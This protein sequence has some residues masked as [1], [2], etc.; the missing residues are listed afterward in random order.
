METLRAILAALG[1]MSAPDGVTFQ[2]YADAEMV[3]VA[4]TVAGRLLSLAV[5]RGGRIDGGQPLFVLDAV[6]EQATRDEAAARLAQA[7][8]RLTDLE[9]GLRP[10][11]IEA[12]AAQKTEAEALLR[13]T[14]LRLER[15]RKLRDSA[16]FMPDRLDE[17]QATRD[18]AR[19][20]VAALAAQLAVARLGGREDALRAARN[21]IEADR[22]ALA[23]AEWTLAQKV[24]AAPAGGLVYDTLFRPGENVGVGQPVVS[25]LPPANRKV[26]FFVPEAQLALVAPGAVVAIACDG[27]GEPIPARVN[28]VSPQAEFTPPVLYN[29]DN[30]VRLVFMVEARPTARPEALH[31]GQPVDVR[32]SPP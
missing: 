13:L 5:Q 28:W 11:E 27:C 19:A 32:M 23:R 10:E 4:P 22:A 20:R 14:D 26:R 9:K 7:E 18:E 31:P 12:I 30:R 16:A 15:Q 1:L 17:A 25:L 8:A 24:V 6:S 2:G 29:R 3:L 21:E